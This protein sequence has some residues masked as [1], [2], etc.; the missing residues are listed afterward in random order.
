MLTKAA[1]LGRT[2]PAAGG[3]SAKKVQ[4][5]P[6][7]KK[8]WRKARKK[9]SARILRACGIVSSQGDA[10]QNRWKFTRATLKVPNRKV[11]FN[12]T[13]ILFEVVHEREGG[14][15]RAGCIDCWDNG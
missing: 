14:S 2:P 3:R 10:I 6:G 1:T 12:T 4:R 11:Q 9:F 15:T 5:P 13:W 8:A 7:T